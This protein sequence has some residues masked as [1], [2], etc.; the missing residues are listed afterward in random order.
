MDDLQYMRN[1]NPHEE[2]QPVNGQEGLNEQ[3]IEG[4]PVNNNIIYMAD[5]RDKAIRDNVLLTPQLIHPGIVRPEV[6]VANFELKPV[7]F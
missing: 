5:D 2:I 6:Q 4:Q 1:L 7:L 3:N